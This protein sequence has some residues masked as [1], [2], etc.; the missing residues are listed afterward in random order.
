MVLVTAKIIGK[1]Q[2]GPDGIVFKLMAPEIAA[3]AQPGQF[4]LIRIGDGYDPLLRRPFSF[5]RFDRKLGTIDILFRIVGKGTT[6]FAQ[7]NIGETCDIFGPLGNGF[8]VNIKNKHQIILAG[9]MGVAPMPALAEQL[10]QSGIF[11]TVLLGAKNQAELWCGPEFEAMGCET[12]LATDDGSLGF[13]GTVM[14]LFLSLNLQSATPINRGKSAILTRSTGPQSAIIYACGPEP[15]LK[16]L[17]AV[18]Q[19]KKFAC[20]ISL[21][22]AMACGVGACQGC[23]VP[24]VG[25]EKYKLV[26]K[27]GPVFDA[28]EIKYY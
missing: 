27:D 15:M 24:V 16:Q 8:Q 13:H 2:V 4:T 12:H 9:G 19:E 17:A 25:A 10:T 1:Q 3:V 22:T 5:H 7:R 14:Q 20:Q 6:L 21:E 18:A 23:I 26:C 28:K 11:P